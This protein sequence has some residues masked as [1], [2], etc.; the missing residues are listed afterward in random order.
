MKF[1]YTH[2]L[3]VII[4]YGN[5]DFAQGNL[6]IHSGHSFQLTVEGASHLSSLP[7]KCWEKEYPYKTGITFLDSSYTS[8]PKEYHPAFYGCYDWHSSVHGH[9][10]LVGLSREDF[11][12]LPDAESIRDK[13]RKHLS[14]ENIEKE[15]AIFKTDNLSFERIYG[16][17]W[18]L[19]LQNELLTWDDPVAKELS[20]N[21]EPL[22]SFFSKA[23]ISFQQDFLSHKSRRTSNLP[24][25]LSFTWEYDNN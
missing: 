8:A 6:F 1:A 2:I 7:L 3:L 15:L 11:P 18:F 19:Y 22:A 17:G 5:S 23:W 12:Q 21:L 25:G 16:W 24:F 9:W 13:L 20:K 14:K 10:M 4:L